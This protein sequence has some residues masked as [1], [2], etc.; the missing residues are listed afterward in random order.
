[1]TPFHIQLEAQHLYGE[2]VH[3]PVRILEFKASHHASAVLNPSQEEAV[4]KQDEGSWPEFEVGD[5]V[6]IMPPGSD[7]PR[8]YS[9]ASCDKEGKLEICVR[10][11]VDGECSS[12]LHGLKEGDVIRV[13]IQ[14]KASF[15]PAQDA[16]AVILIGA[17][18]GMAPLQGFIQQNDQQVP[19]YLYWG[20]RRQNSDFIYEDKLNKALATSRLTQLRLAFSRSAQPRYVQHLLAQDAKTICQRI[21]DGAQI[22]VCGSQT[23]AAGVR[24]TLDGILKAEKL[25]VA[26]L[27]RRGRYLPAVY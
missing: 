16:S 11:Q 21:L 2:E 4:M 1:M 10:K 12:F 14:K 8:Y 26:E 20:G 3:A 7:F 23:M 17:G 25:S 24:V 22:M 27:E 5:L 13:F 9:L 6:G 19:Y 18:T 15:R